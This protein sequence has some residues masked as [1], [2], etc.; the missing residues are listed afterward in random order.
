[1]AGAPD[2]LTGAAPT[3]DAVRTGEVSGGVFNSNPDHSSNRRPVA[4]AFENGMDLPELPRPSD[5][6]SKENPEIPW[7]DRSMQAI[8]SSL[9]LT[10]AEQQK[11]DE[12]ADRMVQTMST[13]EKI[14]ILKSIPRQKYEDMVAQ[15]MN[16][17]H[18]WCHGQIARR[19]LNQKEES[20]RNSEEPTLPESPRPNYQEARTSIDRAHSKNLRLDLSQPPT[21][22]AYRTSSMPDAP[23][24][25]AH[26]AP[27]SD[28][29]ETAKVSGEFS[30]SNLHPRSNPRPATNGF[31]YRMG[32]RT[33]TILDRALSG[34]KNNEEVGFGEG[35]YMGLS[36]GDDP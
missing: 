14:N 9:Q 26:S 25:S 21:S 27:I 6:G 18:T 10:A 15:G 17:I 32:L 28:A 12:I 20:Q 8:Y 24:I 30:N 5:L 23:S 4:N 36:D 11:I 13:V 1:M 16:P 33:P 29:V 31:E 3:S 34:T 7:I 19:F 2:T 22:S 35:C